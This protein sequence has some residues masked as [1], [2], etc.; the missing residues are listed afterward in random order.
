[1]RIAYENVISQPPEVVFPWIADPQKAMQWQK[2]VKG[3]EIILN[4]PEVIGTTFKETIQEDRGS[5]EMSGTITKY[6]PNRLIGFHLDSRI[7]TFDVSY[8]LQ[9]VNK[10]TKFRIEALITWKF[11]MNIV[12]LFAGRRIEEGLVK[13]LETETLDLMKICEKG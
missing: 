12:T 5:L 6:I 1:M 3:G 13:Q 8:S 7:H 9:E 2:D 11:P 4:K 10:K